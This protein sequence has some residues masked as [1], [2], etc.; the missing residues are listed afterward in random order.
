MS[1][2][3][4]DDPDVAAASFVG[5]HMEREG[6]VVDADLAA[7]TTLISIEVLEEGQG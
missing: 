3:N 7:S 6:S 1:E 5:M 2:G 4:E